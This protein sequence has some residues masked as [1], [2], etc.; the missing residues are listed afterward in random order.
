MLGK[1]AL[2]FLLGW[3]P[4][5]LWAAGLEGAF[6]AYQRGDYGKAVQLWRALAEQGDGIAQFNLAQ[7]YRLG[8]G[9]KNDDH[10]AA[11]W[12]VKAAQQGSEQA[13]HNL[14]LMYRHGRASQQDYEAVFGAAEPASAQ[15][16]AP[17]K[18]VVRPS[19]DDWLSSLDPREYVVQ[20]LAS[21]DKSALD[22]V[23]T[24]Y[25]QHLPMPP[26]IARTL[27]KGQ[28]WYVLLLG[29]YTDAGAANTA[30]KTLPADLRK[31]NPWVRKIATVQAAA[32]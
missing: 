3:L 6:E 5:L 1:S 23:I 14:G 16:P 22:E 20:L 25:G 21:A 11:K 30:L 27:S 10:E 28:A 19:Q 13:R 24:A 4:Q 32:R 2:I 12:Y 15:T 26:Q 29:P 31:R 7:M 17:A 18:P 9:V 8:K